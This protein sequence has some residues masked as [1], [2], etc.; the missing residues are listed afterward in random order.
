LSGVGPTGYRE[1]DQRADIKKNKRGHE[2]LEFHAHDRGRRAEQN[3]P[4]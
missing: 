2:L 4:E 3:K 1:H